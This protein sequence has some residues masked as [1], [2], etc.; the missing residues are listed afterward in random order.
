MPGTPDRTTVK[1]TLVEFTT[2]LRANLVA[3][4]PTATKPLRTV[5]PG[6]VAVGAFPRP[7]MAVSLTRLRPVGTVDN[8]R[9]VEVLMALKL[10]ADAS[11]SDPHAEILDIIGATD[12]YLDSII[13]T[14]V[15]EGAEGFDDRVWTFEHPRATAG[16]RV[17]SASATQT[18]VAKVERDYN[19]VPAS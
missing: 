14:G 19:R 11:A 7:F 18:F 10:V 8:D 1:A 16:A 12:D 17:V 4:P 2:K 15:I 13:D 6:V 5:E 3:D 9:V